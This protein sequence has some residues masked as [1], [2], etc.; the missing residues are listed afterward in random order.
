MRTLPEAIEFILLEYITPGTVATFAVELLIGPRPGDMPM[1]YSSTAQEVVIGF[2]KVLLP[3]LTAFTIKKARASAWRRRRLAAVA[4]L[5]QLRVDLQRSAM[6]TSPLWAVSVRAL[7]LLQVCLLASCVLSGGPPAVSCLVSF[8]SAPTVLLVN[9]LRRGAEALQGA[10]GRQPPPPAAAARGAPR[11]CVAPHARCARRVLPSGGAG[12]RR[13]CA[14]GRRRAAGVRGAWARLRNAIYACMHCARTHAR[15]DGASLRLR[16]GWQS[17]GRARRRCGCLGG[18]PVRVAL[19]DISAV[20]CGVLSGPCRCRRATPR[21]GG[22]RAALR[23]RWARLLGTPS[24]SSSAS[25]RLRRAPAR[26]P[27]SRAPLS[28]ASADAVAALR[29]P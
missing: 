3:F 28:A 2:L 9:P 22:T 23:L 24:P 20:L 18:S 10:R 6:E 11:R 16:L 12:R 4:C 15:R 19:T 27:H 17:R 26:H 13:C 8:P 25:S 14:W 21:E 1:I 5:L 29:C 7:S